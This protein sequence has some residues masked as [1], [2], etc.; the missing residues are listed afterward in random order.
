MFVSRIT[1]SIELAIGAHF[2]NNFLVMLVVSPEDA[3]PSGSSMWVATADFAVLDAVCSWVLVTLFVIIGTW[4]YRRNE[5]AA[6][7]FDLSNNEG[8]SPEDR[9][10][11]AVDLG[12]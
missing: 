3:S 9:S 7:L 12:K 11:V 4:L 2:I 10:R 1:G 6:Q 5:H 8:L